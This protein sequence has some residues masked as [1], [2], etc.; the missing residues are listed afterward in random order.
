MKSPSSLATVLLL[1]AVPFG[2][3]YYLYPNLPE[4]IP[5][6]FN[7]KGEADNWSSREGIFLSPAIM[8]VV[9]LIVFFMLT[10]I[11]KIDPKR[12]FK[13]E[14]KVFRQFSLFLVLFLT[15]LSLAILYGTAHFTGTFKNL[16]LPIIALGFMGMGYFLPQLKQNYFAGFRLPWALEDENN[17][18]ATHQ[19][20][21]TLFVWGGLLLFI[22]TILL[23]PRTA[24]YFFLS[25]TLLM[26]L[27]PTAYSFWLFKQKKGT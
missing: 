11:K 6:H 18:N 10:N 14:D 21:G 9:S 26:A 27:I 5:V 24:T 23:E 7:I 1:I 13:G 19:L 17:W 15:L 12:Y 3:A 16:I 20:A 2:Y 4:Q 22:G 25:L 8:A